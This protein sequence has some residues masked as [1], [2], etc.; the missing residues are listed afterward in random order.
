MAQ[1][2]NEKFRFVYDENNDLR[3]KESALKEE[4]QKMLAMIN[5]LGDQKKH[6]LQ[7]KAESE[8]LQRELT[9]ATEQRIELQQR[10][11][12]SLHE[13]SELQR[14]SVAGKFAFQESNVRNAELF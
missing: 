11:E 2:E 12:E 8:R 5:N 13:I 10:L 9:I 14:K 1:Q 4:N 7:E 3:A 6:L